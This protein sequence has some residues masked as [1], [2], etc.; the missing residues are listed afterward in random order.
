MKVAIQ[1]KLV[2]ILQAAEEIDSASNATLDCCGFSNEAERLAFIKAQA[3][4]ILTLA[5]VLLGYHKEGEKDAGDIQG[6]G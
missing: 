4:D 5:A 6:K 1:D 2:E 3:A